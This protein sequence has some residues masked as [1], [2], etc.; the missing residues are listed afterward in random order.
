MSKSK[1]SKKAPKYFIKE[2][3]KVEDTIEE[4][5]EI[6]GYSKTWLSKQLTDGFSAKDHEDKLS[7]LSEEERAKFN[8]LLQ[9]GQSYL[10]YAWAIFRH[11][12]IDNEFGQSNVLSYDPEDKTITI[13]KETSSLLEKVSSSLKGS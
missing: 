3:N 4:A 9:V 2:R 6:L 7:A 10:D 5:S 1:K 12:N 13:P 11:K 8:I